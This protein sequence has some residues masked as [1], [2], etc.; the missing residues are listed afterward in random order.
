[1]SCSPSAG[2]RNDERMHRRSILDPGFREGAFRVRDALAD[3]VTAKRLRSGDLRSPYRGVRAEFGI[4]AT[5]WQDYLPLLRVGDHFSHSTAADIW[6]A[7]LPRRIDDAVHVTAGAGLARPRTHGVAG[8]TSSTSVVANRRGAP[9]SDPTST[10]RELAT[11]LTV[12]ELVALGDYLVLEPRILDPSDP[13][14]YVTLD[15]LRNGMS[16][17]SGRGIR[18]ARAAADL[19]RIGVESPMESALRMLLLRAGLP[20]PVCGYELFEPTGYSVGWFDL[21]WPEYATIAE[22]D[23]DQHRTS[24]LQYEKDIARFDRA[25]ALDWRVI[26]VRRHSI[27]SS[28]PRV[29]AALERGGWTSSGRD[30]PHRKRGRGAPRRLDALRDD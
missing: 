26:R 15:D 28:V 13:R 17:A 20:E 18:T 22:Y 5:A 6:G 30:S 19:V 14:P 2:D 4:A 12:D 23:G 27:R 29:S 11:M 24:T 7:P 16:A 25:A 9:V 8:H 1:M 3:G 21:A 10:F